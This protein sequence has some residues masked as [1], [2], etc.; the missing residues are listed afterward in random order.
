LGTSLAIVGA[1]LV[2]A[3]GAASIARAEDP[4]VP[5]SWHSH[6]LSFTYVGISPTYSCEG[7]R[8]GLS[9]LL[10]KSGAKLNH[11]VYA[12]PCGNFGASRP[13][14]T[15]TLDFSTLQPAETTASGHLAGG[16]WH[17]V[18]FS[19]TH[20]TPDLRGGDCELVEEFKE[21]VLPKFTTRNVK[22]HL[23][24]VPYQTTGD[25]FSLSFDV[26]VAS[27]APTRDS[28]GAN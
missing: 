4:G 7:L 14:L 8:S 23:E 13:P 1:S 20:D 10:Q 9:F 17:H 15:A 22:S 11:P 6:K 28:G 21:T 19:P 25:L 26:L 18:E 5:A 16:E 27:D 24:C 3:S 2:L 12:Y